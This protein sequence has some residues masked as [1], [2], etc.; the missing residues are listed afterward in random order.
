[1]G[2]SGS[3]KSTII[4]LLLRLYDPTG[5]AVL[6][7]GRDVRTLPLRWLRAQVGHLIGLCSSSQDA[8]LHDS[9]AL[10]PASATSTISV[11]IP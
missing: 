3:G 2:E 9:N 7:D 5:G 4:Q 1:M 8:L 6:L 11:P 10:W